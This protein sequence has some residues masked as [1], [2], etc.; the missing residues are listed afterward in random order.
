MI[1]KI[2]YIILIVLIAFFL[3]KLVKK[4]K[5]ELARLH[6]PK[7]YPVVVKTMKPKLENFYLTLSGLGLVKSS[8]DMNVTTKLSGRV[9]YI[10]DIGDRVKKGD[11]VARLDASE[12]KALLSKAESQ[13]K[14]LYAKL[15]AAKLSLKNL[16]LTH[17]RTAEL[18]KVK[19]ASIEQYQKEQDQLASL[20]SQIDSL[21]SEIKAT[22][23]NIEHLKILLTYAII[24]SPVNGVISK[25]FVNV[26]DVALPGRALCS[27]SAR[28]GKYI[29]LRLPDDVKPF[30]L[31]FNGKFYQVVSLNNTFNGLNE[32]KADVKTTLNTNTRVKV[33]IV[34]FKGE[35][36]K[37][38]FDAILSD[39]GKDFVFVVKGKKAIPKQVKIIASGEEGL[40]V[41]DRSLLGQELVLAKPDIFIKLRGGVGIVK[42]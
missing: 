7:V 3:V 18:L 23:S 4:R 34:I 24:K 20:R 5:E 15:S 16:K 32:Y 22:D 41:L 28:G 42:E 12:T 35:A 40:A 11:I 8:V 38:P 31:F 6:T 10:K 9:L 19:G 13:L 21:K 2:I 14:S 25:K 33:G 39:N 1:K 36:I 30:G 17:M 29:L 27:I 37:L 26:G